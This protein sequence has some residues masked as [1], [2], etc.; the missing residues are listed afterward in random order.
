MRE[1]VFALEDA[2]DVQFDE[3]EF[4]LLSSVSA[5]AALVESRRAA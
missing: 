2:Y 3:S 1:I 5:I 4:P